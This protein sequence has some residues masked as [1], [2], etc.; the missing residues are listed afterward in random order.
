MPGKVTE[1]VLYLQLMWETQ[2]GFLAPGFKWPSPGYCNHL[3]IKLDNGRSL[4]SSLS[5][6]IN[7]YLKK[8]KR[9]NRMSLNV[10][11]QDQIASNC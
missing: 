4:Y 7:E 9:K 1:D 11:A 5:L 3:E 2:L 8:K 6:S 10:S